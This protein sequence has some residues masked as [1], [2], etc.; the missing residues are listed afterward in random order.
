MPDT[1]QKELTRNGEPFQLNY[2]ILV[3]ATSSFVNDLLVLT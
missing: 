1:Q 3:T 2:S